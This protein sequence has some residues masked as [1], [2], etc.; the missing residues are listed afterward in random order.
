M[1][2]SDMYYSVFRVAVNSEHVPGLRLK[3][4]L[5]SIVNR[6][7]IDSCRCPAVYLIGNVTLIEACLDE[8]RAPAVALTESNR[9]EITL[10]LRSVIL[11]GGFANANLRSVPT[12]Y[13]GIRT[14]R[15]PEK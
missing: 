2:E 15:I 12:F 6:L 10:N 4:P 14:K 1:K 9:L 11:A 7:A 8:C 13:T 5:T 3:L